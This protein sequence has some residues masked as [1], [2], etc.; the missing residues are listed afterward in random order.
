[1]TVLRR[2]SW[3]GLVA[4]A[5]GTLAV[6][7]IYASYAYSLRTAS[8]LTGWTL[9]AVMIWL[10]LLNARKKINTVPIGR[11]TLWVDVHVW[12]GVLAVAI[13]A[14]H[15]HF[16]EPKGWVEGALAVV[17]GIAVVSGIVGIFL[18]RTVPRRLRTRGEQVIFERQPI[19]RRRLREELDGVVAGVTSSESLS[20]FYARRLIPFFAEPRNLWHHLLQSRTPAHA[21]LTEL[22]GLGRY[23]DENERA[24]QQTIAELIRVKDD[25]DYHYAHQ[26]ALKYWL[27]VHIPVAYTLLVLAIVHVTLV[28]TYRGP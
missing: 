17:F 7:V 27:F 14:V 22:D 21:L 13:F 8:Y 3:V 1:M 28:Y 18:S 2:E 26:T 9:F 20:D 11:A 15:V 24:A 5:L 6:L 25:L 12:L 16:R 19:F 23:L 4:V 10:A